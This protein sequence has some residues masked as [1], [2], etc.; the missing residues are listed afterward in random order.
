MFNLDGKFNTI[1]KLNIVQNIQEEN[2]QNQTLRGLWKCDQRLGS[3]VVFY[4]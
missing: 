1:E 2:F 3:K 4:H